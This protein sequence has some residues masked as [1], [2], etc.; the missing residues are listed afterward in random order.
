MIKHSH[1]SRWV[2]VSAAL[3]VLMLAAGAHARRL[4]D[5]VGTY[6]LLTAVVLQPNDTEPQSIQLKGAFAVSDAKPG[7]GYLPAAAGYLYFSCPRGKDATCWN[8]WSDLKKLAGAGQIAGIG[9]RFGPLGRVRKADEP[10][11]SPD[12]YPIAMGVFTS[13]RDTWMDPAILADL[14]KA[15]KR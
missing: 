15:L 4:S 6:C 9:S 10:L 11:G 3:L 14:R 1:H 7:G 2:L 8:E 12:P 5:P 13:A